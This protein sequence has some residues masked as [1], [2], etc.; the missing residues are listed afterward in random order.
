MTS[1]PPAGAPSPFLTV[2]IGEAKPRTVISGLAK[3]VP[4]EE[5]QNR[6]IVLCCNLK[7]R[8]YVCFC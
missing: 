7:P 6:L 4:I 2:D 3:F 1:E 5:M 8:K